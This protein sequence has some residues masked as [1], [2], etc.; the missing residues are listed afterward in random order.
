VL[1]VVSL[2]V[3][4]LSVV[5]LRVVAPLAEFNGEAAEKHDIHCLQVTLGPIR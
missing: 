2:C 1:R 5:M 3:E 4:M